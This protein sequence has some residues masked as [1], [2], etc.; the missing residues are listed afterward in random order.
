MNNMKRTY[1]HAKLKKRNRRMRVLFRV[2]REHVRERLRI[3]KHNSSRAHGT[4]HLKNGAI[5]LRPPVVELSG[6]GMCRGA[7]YR[8]FLCVAK[9]KA[10]G[11]RS[12]EAEAARALER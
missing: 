11:R 3:A 6:A 12:S 5:G 4:M 9:D 10:C 8:G 2:E 7:G 1:Q